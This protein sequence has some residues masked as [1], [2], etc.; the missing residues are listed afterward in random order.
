MNKEI[1]KLTWSDVRARLVNPNMFPPGTYFGIPRG[2]AIVA[3]LLAALRPNDCA[4][5][6]RPEQAS[7]I[8]DDIV[9]SGKTRS[10]WM[11]KHPRCGFVPLVDK[12]SKDVCLGWVQFPWEKDGTTD[13]EDSVVRLLEFLG[14]DPN[15]EGLQETPKRVVKAWKEM[16]RGYGQDPKAI[17]SKNFDSGHYDEMICLTGAEFFSTCEHHMLPFFGHAHVAYVPNP[18]TN[19]VVGISKLARLVDCFARRLQIQEQLTQQIANAVEESLNPLG[20]GVVLEAKHFCMCVRGVEKQQST[21]FTSSMRG[22]FH[23]GPA[24]A[25]FLS[26]VNLNRK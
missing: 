10:L 24:R 19:R 17:L 20:V 12:R 21:M 22:C 5:V 13:V 26:L 3:G 18:S 4:V 25:E 1:H 6:D 14:E 23:Q 16:T 7:Y 15:R 11:T 8:T 2:G 9:D